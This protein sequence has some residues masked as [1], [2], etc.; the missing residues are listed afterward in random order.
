MGV[1]AGNRVWHAPAG[2]LGWFASVWGPVP[3]SWAALPA[4]PGVDT[5]GAADGFLQ[6]VILD[7][8]LG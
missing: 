7:L 3:T 6:V 5:V 1:A 8:I 2:L 4:I